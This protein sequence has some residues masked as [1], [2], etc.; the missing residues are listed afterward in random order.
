[1]GLFGFLFVGWFGFGGFF[2]F[3]FFFRFLARC[4]LLY[5]SGVLGVPYAFNKPSLLLIKKKDVL[6]KF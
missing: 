3:F 6:Q 5:T 4:F 2:F 1:V